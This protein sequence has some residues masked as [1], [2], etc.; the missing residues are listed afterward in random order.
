[1]NKEEGLALLIVNGVMAVLFVGLGFWCNKRPASAIIAGMALYG[2]V[3]LI[4]AIDNPLTIVQGVIWKIVIIGAM[5]R[6]LKA[7]FR[8]EKIK[9]EL[10]ID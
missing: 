1:M 2:F 4:N 8:A 3:Q 10:S 6:G 7:A 9:K 5:V